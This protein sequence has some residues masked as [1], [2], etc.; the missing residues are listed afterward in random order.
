MR[1]LVFLVAAAALAAPFAAVAADDPASTEGPGPGQACAAER[2]AIGG[3][4]FRA[5][6]GTNANKSNAFG[7]CVSWNA[8]HPESSSSS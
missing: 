8:R 2:T 4:A 6:Y 5:L 1:K 3:D 7:K